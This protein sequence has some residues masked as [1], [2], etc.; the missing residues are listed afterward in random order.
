MYLRLLDLLRCPDC[1]HHLEVDVLMPAAAENASEIGEGLLHCDAGHWFPVVGGIPRML[2]AS[3]Q[4][5]WDTL[6]PHM[7]DLTSTFAKLTSGYR[8]NGA[9]P[10]FDRRT[11]ESFSLEW[12]NHEVGDR[13]WGM[14][15]DHRVKTFFLDSIGIPADQLIGKVMLD[16]GCGNGS[17]SVAYTALG[18]EVIA[19]DLSSGLEH[20]QAFRH[21]L[22]GARPQMVHFVQ[23]DLERPPLAPGTVDLIHSAGVLHHTLDTEATFRRLC[24]LLGPGGTFYVWLYKYEP[25]VTPLVNTIRGITTRLPRPAIAKL[26]RVLADPFRGFCRTVNRLGIRRYPRLSRREAALALLD[27]FGAPHAHYHSFSDVAR[28]YESEHFEEVWP[29]NETRRGFGV[30]GRQAVRD[31]LTAPIQ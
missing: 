3:L 9:Q 10:D 21:A 27:I 30:C 5:H 6:E 22:P 8:Q 28:W 2:P 18:L 31:E 24:P 4:E 26:A 14:D 16:A 12:D 7:G 11:R 23:A 20:G 29:C 25:I 15:L 13:T 19:L 17:Q 1:H